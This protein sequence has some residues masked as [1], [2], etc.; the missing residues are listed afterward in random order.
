MCEDD[1]SCA[2]RHHHA[3]AHHAA[4]DAVQL[5]LLLPAAVRGRAVQPELQLL[6]AAGRGGGGGQAA[7]LQPVA[8]GQEEKYSFF[9]CDFMHHAKHIIY[10]SINL[11]HIWGL[12]TCVLNFAPIEIIYLIS[13]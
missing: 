2:G 9:L 4:A 5:E 11:L 10:T 3:G 8:G 6:Q 12:S 1:L 7:A 13:H